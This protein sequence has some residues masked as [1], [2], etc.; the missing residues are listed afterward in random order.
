MLVTTKKIFDRFD[1]FLVFTIYND[2]YCN[3]R[4]NYKK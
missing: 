1:K 2:V 3:Y 4:K